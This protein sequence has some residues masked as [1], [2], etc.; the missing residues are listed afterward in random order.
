M[1]QF[2]LKFLFVI[3]LLIPNSV[4]ANSG[5]KRLLLTTQEWPPYQTY[6]S[7]TI[8]GL[9]VTRL[10]CVLRQLE[11][12]YQLTMT[13]WEN[14]QLKVQDNE[15]HGFFVA[16][17]TPIRDKYATFSKPLINHHWYWYFSNSLSN[18]DLTQSNKQQWKV[19]SKFG[20][21]KWFY[22][23]NKNYDVIKT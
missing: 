11:Q 3:F 1:S 17:Q 2:I 8:S 6:S 16:E 20:T 4:L 15:Q 18:I 23:H 10:K 9:A 19:S 7:D 14:A 5:P 13:S 22:L 21:N 12:P